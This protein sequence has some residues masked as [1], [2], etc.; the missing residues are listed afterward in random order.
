MRSR[1]L[2]AAILLVWIAAAGRLSAADNFKPFKMKT[3]EGTQRALPDVM[4]KA[5]LVVFFFPTCPYCNAA[6][7]EMQKLYDSYKEQGLAMVWINVVQDEERLIP[8]WRTKHGY[9]VPILLGGR[10]VQNDYKLVQTPTHYLLDS[11]G[12]VLSRHDGYRAGDEK[13]L[14]RAIQEAIAAAP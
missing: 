1:V 7:P 9:T 3:L 10:S 12:K 11:K 14:E 2:Y 8:A 5:T 6:F 13:G 4:G